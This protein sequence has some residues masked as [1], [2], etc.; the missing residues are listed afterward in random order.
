MFPLI[1]IYAGHNSK[2][3]TLIVKGNVNGSSLYVTFDA[4]VYME[5]FDCMWN[6]G[7]E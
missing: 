7:A 1:S 4:V 2:S 5:H 3:G 6:S